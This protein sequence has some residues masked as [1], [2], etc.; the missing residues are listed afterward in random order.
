M[1][2]LKNGGRAAS[3]RARAGGPGCDGLEKTVSAYLRL[4][5]Y[6]RLTAI[7]MQAC[8]HGDLSRWHVSWPLAADTQCALA[9]RADSEYESESRRLSEQ[10]GRLALGL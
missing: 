1:P 2:P 10:A 9:A 6:H 4:G 7:M 3:D 8:L 5:N